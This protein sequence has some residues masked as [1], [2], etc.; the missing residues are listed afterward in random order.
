MMKGQYGIQCCR[1]HQQAAHRHALYRTLQLERDRL[2][3]RL[4]DLKAE[5]LLQRSSPV[6]GAAASL[7][8][9][10]ALHRALRND[11]EALKQELEVHPLP[12]ITDSFHGSSQYI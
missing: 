5:S 12:Y 10:T 9:D 1:L 3:E 11:K 4:S 7:P 6:P 2:E 8:M